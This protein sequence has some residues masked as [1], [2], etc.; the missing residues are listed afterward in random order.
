MKITKL[1]TLCA[2]I[3]II[4]C[5]SKEDKVV[6]EKIH[7]IE[8]QGHRGERGNLPENS[9]EAFLGA[10]QKGVDVLELDVVVSKD[11]KV[12]VSHEPF[13]SALYMSKPSGEPVIKEEEKS[14]NLYEM[15][16]DSIKAFDGGSRGN[17]KFPNQQKIKTYKPLL[18]EVFKVIESEIKSEN[19]TQVKYNIEIK[20]AE[21]VYGIYQ[22]QPAEFVDLVTQVIAENRMEN[23]VNIQ[24]FD[25]IILNVLHKKCP[26]VE[27]AYL[28]S[29]G[30]IKNNLKHLNFKPNI[31]SP[32]F[33]LITNKQSVDSLRNMNVKLIPWTVNN[34]EDIKQQIQLKVDGIITDYPERVMSLTN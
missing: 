14:F 30:S 25:P 1:L 8:V 9:I 10:L 17:P 15:T 13:M 34:M 33:K 3:S 23:R 32:N 21:A 11:Q 12:V 2:L 6:A 27:I 19:L 28:V 16:Y 24:S 20:S 5:R 22:P 7:K 29:K 18:S 4:S 26:D 31:Y